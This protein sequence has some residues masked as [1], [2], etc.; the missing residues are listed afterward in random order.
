[1]TGLKSYKSNTHAWFSF[2]QHI[3]LELEVTPSKLCPEKYNFENCC[4]S[5]SYRQDA[6]P[7]AQPGDSEMK[8]ETWN[9]SKKIMFPMLIN[10]NKIYFFIKLNNA[11]MYCCGFSC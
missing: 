6:L 4:G 10:I 5:S 7:V 9:L 2:N 1:M 11:I 8:Y 3:F